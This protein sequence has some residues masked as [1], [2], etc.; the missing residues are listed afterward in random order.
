MTALALP[1]AIEASGFSQEAMFDLLSNIKTLINELQEDHATFRTAVNA[2]RTH[3]LSMA[4][5]KSGLAIG[6]TATKYKHTTQVAFMAGGL[7]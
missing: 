3:R 2:L 6:G 1:Q 5:A 4:F 7:L